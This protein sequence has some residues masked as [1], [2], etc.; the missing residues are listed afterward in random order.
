M[1]KREPLDV[2]FWRYVKKGDGCWEWMASKNKKGYGSFGTGDRRTS[3]AHRV[4][5]VLN[6]GII[7]EGFYV[8]HKCNN[9]GCVRP[10]HL[11]LG[12]QLDNMNDRKRTTGY[13]L[14]GENNPFS[15]FSVEDIRNIRE[16]SNQG[17]SRTEIAE[18][19]ECSI[20]AISS[21]ARGKTW[22]EMELSEKGQT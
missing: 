18:F 22:A 6:V 16:L 11:Y 3:L 9:P 8:L 4:S 17:K 1:P 13:N 14:H 19:Y 12:T 5:W 20:T 7:P 10:S 2:R 15:R 21:I